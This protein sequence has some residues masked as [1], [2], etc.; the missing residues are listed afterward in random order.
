[1]PVITALEVHQRN[2]ESVKLFL[3]DKFAM[4]L[5]LLQ[6]AQLHQGQLL[7]QAEVDALAD[8]GIFQSA[9]DRAVRFLSYRPRSIAEV[10]RYLVNAGVAASIIDAVLERLQQRG[11]LDDLAF[12]KFWLENRN[13]FKPMAPRA[14][15]HELWRKDVDAGIID[16]VLSEFDAEEAAYRAAQGRLQ[17]YKGNT[18]QVF[19]RKLSGMLRRRG[20]DSETIN[21]VVLRLQQR[22]DE[23][24]DGYFDRDVDE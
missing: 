21:D 22:L 2:R 12:A 5:P 10:R 14:L 1:M 16:A 7:T 9:F 19:R 18:R 23:S 13:R 6:A 3:D 4:D 17:R 20:F 11:Y 24:E 15:R 8:A